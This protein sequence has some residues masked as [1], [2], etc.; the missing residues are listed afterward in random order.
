MGS[1]ET[2]RTGA[3]SLTR[4]Y[5]VALLNV[6]VTNR[7]MLH[8]LLSAT[9]CVST[10]KSRQY[11]LTKKKNDART[12][13]THHLP[14]AKPFPMHALFTWLVRTYQTYPKVFTTAAQST[15]SGRCRSASPPNDEGNYFNHA[16]KN[17]DGILTIRCRTTTPASQ[18]HPSARCLRRRRKSTTERLQ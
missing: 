11:L 3:R 18:S 14:K 10:G 5:F 2:F 7:A 17:P 12:R 16:E 8:L 4:A 9:K 13:L 6:H 1:E 15:R